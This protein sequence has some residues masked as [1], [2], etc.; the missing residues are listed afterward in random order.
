MHLNTGEY[1]DYRCKNG[2]WAV[3]TPLCIGAKHLGKDGSQFPVLMEV[4]TIKDENHRLFSRVYYSFGY[5]IASSRR[6]I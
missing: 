5:P 6:I 4:T 1:V 3:V 2:L